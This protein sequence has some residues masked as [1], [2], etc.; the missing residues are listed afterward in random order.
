MKAHLIRAKDCDSEMYSGLMAL[1]RSFPGPIQFIESEELMLDEDGGI[2]VYESQEDEFTMV[3]QCKICGVNSAESHPVD[4]DFS[5]QTCDSCGHFKISGSA[6]AVKIDGD[7]PLI[8]I[9][10]HIQRYGTTEKPAVLDVET[11]NLLVAAVFPSVS[12]R[13]EFLLQE[14]HRCTTY[15]GQK[16]DVLTKRIVALTY[17]VVDSDVR[18]LADYL[19]GDVYFKVQQPGQNLHRA[20]VQFK[21]TEKIEQKKP[22]ICRL[23]DET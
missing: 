12:E 5:D 2:V 8:K 23:I 4:G 10:G 1:L 11:M 16:I 9:R 15:L 13:A 21:L 14:V 17:S 18:F 6:A 22:E 7:R 20:W 3:D 19:N